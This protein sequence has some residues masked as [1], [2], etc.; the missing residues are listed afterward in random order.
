MFVCVY[1]F[2]FVKLLF[3][4]RSCGLALW[5]E[6]DKSGHIRSLYIT[7]SSTGKDHE[8]WVKTLENSL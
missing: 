3:L 4:L 5:L 6:F 2:S 8:I 7:W 1:V